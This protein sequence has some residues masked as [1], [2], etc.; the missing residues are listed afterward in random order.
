MAT[1]QYRCPDCGPFDLTRPIGEALREEPCTV[2]GNQSRRV[3]TAPLLARTSGALARALRVQ[4]ASAHEPRV[5]GEVPAARR[6]P[7]PATDPR[8]ALL[9]K[10]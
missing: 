4:E 5:V 8:H 3:F 6:G 1:Y 9:P 7:A 2:C 10:P